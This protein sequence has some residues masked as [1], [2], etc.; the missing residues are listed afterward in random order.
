MVRLVEVNLTGNCFMR[1]FSSISG[2]FPITGESD[3]RD[4][5]P[6]NIAGTP[7][8]I[9]KACLQIYASRMRAKNTAKVSAFSGRN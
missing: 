3:R 1:P 5:E 8:A 2:S 6:A 9:P 4:F 7:A